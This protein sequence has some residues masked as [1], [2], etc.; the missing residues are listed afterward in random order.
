MKT[1]YI[2]LATEVLKNTYT[3]LTMLDNDIEKYFSTDISAGG[4]T[5][6]RANILKYIE[7]ATFVNKY[8]RKLLLWTYSNENVAAKG[9][10]PDPFS[11]IEI[12]WMHEFRNEYINS[13]RILCKEPKVIIETIKNIPNIIVVPNEVDVVEKTIGVST[14]DPLAMGLTLVEI[15]P[16]YLIGMK[17][18]EWQASRYHAG[19]EEKRSLEYRLLSLK[20][21]LAGRH[22]AKLER[23]IEYTENRVRKL[24]IK[25][26][27]LEEV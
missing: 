21:N 13:I 20:E 1:N 5:Y 4:I 12:K 7:V 3:T 23:E 8:S 11:P 15:T 10:I 14:I 2:S 18:V 17:F 26:A 27:K 22:D 19:V 25:L 16:A 24:N 9:K 6:S